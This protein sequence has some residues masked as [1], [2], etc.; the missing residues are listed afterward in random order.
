MRTI[1]KLM[2]TL[3]LLA[4]GVVGVNA[5]KLYATYSTPAS[6]GTWNA[7]TN[8]YTWTEGWSNLMTIFTFPNGELA[9]Y[10]SLH[11]TTSDY[12]TGPYRVCFMIGSD[13]AA[14]IAFYSEGTKNLV[15]SE[16]D[17]TK[18]L[19]LS[20]ITHISFG[21]ASGSGS[22]KLVSTP[23]LQKPMSLDINDNGQAIIDKT[24]L[25]ASGCLTLNDETG[26]LTSTLGEEGAP[27]WGRLSINFP[28]GGVDLSNLTGFTVNQSGTVLFSNFEI[29]SKGFWSNI[30]GRGDLAQYVNDFG[31]PAHV[32]TWRWNV[33]KAGTQTINSV[34]L[35]FAVMNASNPHETLLTNALFNGSCESHFGES[36]GPGTTIYGNG[37]VLAEQYADLSAYDE[38]R[39]YGTP[40]KKIRLLFNWGSANQKE[41]TGDNVKLDENGYYSLDLSTVA[42]QQLNAFKFPW[43]GQNGVITKVILYK[44]NIP[45]AYDYVIS[46][47]GEKTPSVKTALADANATSID[48]TGVTKATELTTA[49]PN[50]LI[51]ANA[52]MVTNAQNVIVNGTC[53]NLVLTD[54]YD[55]KAPADFTATAASYTTTI[56]ATAQAGTL[57]LPFAATLP[58]D[59]Q[60][61]TLTYSSG[62]AAEA[63]EVQTTIPAST[64]VLL[65]GSGEVTFSGS[66]AVAAS[67]ENKSG[68]MT[69]VFAKGFVPKD[70]YV[71]QLLD[72]GLGFRKVAADNSV[73][74]NPFRA[75]LTAQGA[76]SR[77]SINFGEVTGIETVA[78]AE[79]NEGKAYDL[80]GRRVAQP[81]KGLYI[82]NGKKYIVK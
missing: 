24:D 62:D 58:S 39:I 48:A 63:T 11:L 9:D 73:S 68:A 35:H 60:A 5:T 28:E 10:K 4:V 20:K 75:Y 30:M 17:E 26:V 41:I 52:G 3:L 29:G 34:T 25:V 18:N 33:D 46:G 38:M 66:G 31:D 32:T 82:V 70:S 74:I 45:V 27:T 76:G 55:F 22:I 2:L 19:D 36:V 59:V 56:N 15:F 21:G 12:V 72:S 40:G 7:E 79:K 54:G 14:T 49:N 77:L 64:P 42:P 6:N 50:C 16:R 80:Q 37:S 57:C 8:T 65:N 81:T 53:A 1:K 13:A 61:Y 47:A 71:L 51:V 43:D 67:A 23:Y 78:T 44:E 69:G